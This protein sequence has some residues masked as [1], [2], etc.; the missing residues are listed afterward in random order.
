[1]SQA[2]RQ[3]LMSVLDEDHAL[4]V[5]EHR[6]VTI[7]KPLTVFAARLLAKRFAAWGDPNEAA[8]IMIEKVW[9][10]FDPSWV[11]K[12]QPRLASPRKP[13]AFDAYQQIANERGWNEPEILPS[14]HG[15]VERLPAEQR[16]PSGTVVDL[17]SGTDW[18]R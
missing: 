10:G 9:Q 7:K 2:I 13:N 15:N 8:E 5:I 4:A 3:V 16:G 14:N 18:R 6:R 1:M 11:S 17:R 12:F